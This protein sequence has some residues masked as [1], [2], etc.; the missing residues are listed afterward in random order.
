MLIFL[1]IA[2]PDIAQII[3]TQLNFGKLPLEAL[4]FIT[5]MEAIFSGIMVSFLSMQLF[6][7]FNQVGH[8]FEAPN[9]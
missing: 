6:K 4:P 9:S 8:K 2:R 7:N 3:Q 1:D 5:L